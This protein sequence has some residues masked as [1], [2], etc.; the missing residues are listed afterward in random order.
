MDEVKWSDRN[1]CYLGGRCPTSKKEEY[2]R[3]R[4]R[5]FA[6]LHRAV[7]F[8]GAR[9][10]T[11]NCHRGRRHRR[12]LATSTFPS[13]FSPSSGERD[14]E[15]WW[16]TRKGAWVKSR[17]MFDWN[18]FEWKEGRRRQLSSL[19]PRR[20]AQ[21]DPNQDEIYGLFVTGSERERGV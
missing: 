21:H 16:G 19:K 2:Q 12:V 4:R 14:L 13:P 11:D 1:R 8:R 5:D 6:R 17:E 18:F 20:S 10:P 7:G 9:A 3:R 15:E